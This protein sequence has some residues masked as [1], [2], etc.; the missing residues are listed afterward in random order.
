MKKLTLRLDDLRIESFATVPA[1]RGAG[2][3]RAHSSLITYAGP[4]CD[5]VLA[6]T[7]AASCE[8]YSCDTTCDSG[9]EGTSCE[10]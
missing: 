5:T 7:C 6:P 1:A 8:V 2:T 9:Y 3:V 4:E 10:P